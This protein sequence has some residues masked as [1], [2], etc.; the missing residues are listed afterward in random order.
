[1]STG[2]I[3]LA[4]NAKLDVCKIGFTT[5]EPEDRLRELSTGSPSELILEGCIRGGPQLESRLH[6]W[7]DDIRIKGEW[8]DLDREDLRNV[9]DRDWRQ[10]NGFHSDSGPPPRPP[11]E[12]EGIEDEKD[13]EEWERRG[14]PLPDE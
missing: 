14:F 1:M 9:L 3:Y 11:W 8:F 5:R 7:F 2:W 4:R 13:W 10:K 6:E 12:V